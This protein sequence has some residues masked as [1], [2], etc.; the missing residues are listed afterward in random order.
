MKGRREGNEGRKRGRRR[1]G[2]E[3]KRKEGREGRREGGEEGGRYRLREG[4]KG[5]E[6]NFAHSSLK[7][8]RLH[9]LSSHGL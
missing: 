3:G 8:A 9:Q 6:T 4:G 2:R 1:E 5:L 7:F